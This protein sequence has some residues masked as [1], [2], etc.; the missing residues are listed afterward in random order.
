MKE[1]MNFLAVS[2]LAVEFPLVYLH[3]PQTKAGWISL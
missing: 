2:L 1:G 3:V